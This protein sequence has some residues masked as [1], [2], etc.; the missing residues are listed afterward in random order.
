MPYENIATKLLAIIQPV[1]IPPAHGYQVPKPLV[2]Q[3]M[4]N[5]LQH[6]LTV[7]LGGDLVIKQ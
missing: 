2:C 5:I 6:L 4:G 3:L 1:I 7:R